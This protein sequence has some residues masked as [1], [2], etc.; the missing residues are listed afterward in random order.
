MILRLSLSVAPPQ[1]PSFS[2]VA[3][4]Y[5]KQLTR[6]G[7]SAQMHFASSAA[8]SESG[9]NTAGSRPLQAP[10]CL[11]D[12]SDLDIAYPLDVGATP[13]APHRMCPWSQMSNPRGLRGFPSNAIGPS[14]DLQ[15]ML[16]YL[17]CLFDDHGVCKM[18]VTGD[19]FTA[20]GFNLFS[21]F[22]GHR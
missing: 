3:K 13:L 8:S 20:G 22:F 16:R 2:R 21:K 15:R 7:H 12:N 4:A 6:T 5:S 19:D 11:H 14:N 1:T 18:A 10:C 9:K 17:A